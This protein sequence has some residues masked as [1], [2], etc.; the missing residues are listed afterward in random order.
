MTNVLVFLDNFFTGGVTA[1]ATAIYR[2]LDKDK[3]SM[4][5]ARRRVGINEIDREI[6]ENGNTVYYYDYIPLNRI[7]VLNY[8]IQKIKIANQ[9]INQIKKSGK[10]YD[11]IHI[12]ANPIIGLYI[13]KRLG[14]PV[15][16]MHAHE[17]TPDFGDNINSSRLT[18]FLW[19]RRQRAYNRLAT[20][21][22]GDSSKACRVK[23]GENVLRDSKMQVL[24]PP[25]DMDKFNP[26]NYNE[27]DIDILIDKSAFNIIHVGRL[28][29]VKN[30]KFLIDILKSVLTKTKAHLYVVGD[31]DIKQRLLDYANKL[32]VGENI[33]F[34]PPDTSPAI[35]KLMNCSL[36]PSFSEAFGMVAVESQLMSAPCFASTNVPRDVD[37]GMC[38]FLPLESGADAWSRAVLDFNYNSA[39]VNEN[40]KKQFTIANLVSKSEKLYLNR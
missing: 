26:E 3:F 18:A 10:K 25:I 22:A 20:V 11:A 2:N 35:Y 24:F 15:R 28:N 34:L 23:F 21:K 19:K 39:A 4:D 38:S 5:F 8:E 12:H 29:P 14:I 9:I 31:G 1:V 37:V 27:A 30:Q 33:T 40:A 7:P 6:T 13:G 17:A 16:I 32:G 36:L